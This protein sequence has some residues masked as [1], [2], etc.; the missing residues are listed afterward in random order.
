MSDVRITRTTTE[1]GELHSTPARDREREAIRQRAFELFMQR[2]DNSGNELDD[3]CAA[4]REI[5]G[6]ASGDV[7]EHG[8]AYD[9]DVSLP[10]F[11]ARE[12]E[13]TATDNEV[14]VH[15]L[16]MTTRD[17]TDANTDWSES[18]ES[19]IYRRFR[20]PTPVS[21]ERISARFDDGVLH[22]HAPKSKPIGRTELMPA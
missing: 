13:I 9:V 8:E 5:L 15:A 4:E 10:G 6:M 20:L 16:M 12:V 7:L 14:V 11:S 22:V 1:A 3:W 18:V 21:A 2:G 19:E 17:D